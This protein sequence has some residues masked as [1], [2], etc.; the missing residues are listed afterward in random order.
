[1]T[2]IRSGDGAAAEEHAAS[3]ATLARMTSATRV[4]CWASMT[5]SD[6]QR[7]EVAPGS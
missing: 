5:V 4:R 6:W 2:V 3:S 1:V 7:D